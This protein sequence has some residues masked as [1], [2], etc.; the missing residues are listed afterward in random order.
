[1]NASWD[2]PGAGRLQVYNPCSDC[3]GYSLHSRNYPI[4][5]S[6]PSSASPLGLKAKGNRMEGKTQRSLAQLGP[7]RLATPVAGFYLVRMRLQATTVFVS[8]RGGNH[9]D[10]TSP[11]TLSPHAF[12]DVTQSPHP[13]KP[14]TNLA[15]GGDHFYLLQRIN[16]TGRE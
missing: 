7:P 9:S 12:V 10:I 11:A 13:Q 14:R 15:Q 5:C 16:F 4:T 3:P 8:P 1:M 2:E 6:S